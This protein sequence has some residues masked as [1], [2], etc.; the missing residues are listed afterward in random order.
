MTV[1]LLVDTNRNRGVCPL[2]TKRK[3]LAPGSRLCVLCH[4]GQVGHIKRLEHL[5][6]DTTKALNLSRK[7]LAI[8]KR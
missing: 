5:V 4:T 2:C 8:F 3:A 6:N 7:R 1:E